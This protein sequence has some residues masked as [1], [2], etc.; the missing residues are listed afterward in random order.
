MKILVAGG[1]GAGKTTLL[2]SVSEVVPRRAEDMLTAS[3]E[4][5]ESLAEA[6]AATPVGLDFGRISIGDDLLVYLFGAPGQPR[7]W[8][9]WDELARGALG[10][11]VVADT[12]RLAD[13][14]ASVDYCERREL[15]FVVAVNCFDDARRYPEDPVRIALD[16]D[17]D[18]PLVLC[19]TRRRESCRDVLVTLA[20]HALRSAGLSPARRPAPSGRAC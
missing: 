7:F 4:S 9:L 19:D 18:V 1:E 6:A 2:D 20:E 12:R 8:F 5:A 10:A 14:F 13:C 17:A 16:L 11:V 15:P 3:G